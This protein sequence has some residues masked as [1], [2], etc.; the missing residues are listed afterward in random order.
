ML[1]SFTRIL[2]PLDGSERAE[3]AILVAAKVA[4][5]T[6]GTIVLVRVIPPLVAYGPAFAGGAFAPV[7]PVLSDEEQ[8]EVAAY[9]TR[10]AGWPVLSGIPVETQ[11]LVGPAAPTI[12]DV[13]SEQRV[14][15]I[16]LT[17]HGRTGVTR[18]VLG[19]VA[20][21]LVQHA[22]VPILM[23]R[24]Y[25]PSPADDQ[26]EDKHL[27]RVLAPLDGSRLAEESLV[28]AARLITALAAPTQGAL[29][30]IFVVSPYDEYIQGIPEAL[31]VGS[32][33]GYLSHVA[34]QL[35]AKY[36]GL[37]VTSS[38]ITNADI[39]A[40]VIHAAEGDAGAEV[41]DVGNVPSGYDVIAMATHG[42]SGL[43]RWMMG[44]IT[45]RVMQTTNRPLLIVRPRHVS[46]AGKL[47]HE[48]H[49]EAKE[50]TWSAL[51]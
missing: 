17:S 38:V 33:K 19:S 1:T 2:V 45:E 21:H 22:S 3:R 34:E 51:F 15:A 12:L 25:G 18:W 50:Y 26:L 27:F 29:H 13:A 5:T 7:A 43:T 28:P 35:R 36:A 42:R 11:L 4:R 20:Q 41:A 16:I 24:E 14:D 30:L 6:G 44:S 10:I 32:A 23:L 37:Q 8:A 40:G 9:L 49:H 48:E 46:D 31:I 39:A 47:A